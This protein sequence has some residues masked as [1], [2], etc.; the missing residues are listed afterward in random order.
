VI[1]VATRV[2]LLF[3]CFDP[4]FFCSMPFRRPTTVIADTNA[5]CQGGVDFLIR[6]LYPMARLKI[7]AIVHMEILN[8]T[9][10]YFEQRRKYQ[11]TGK[12]NKP[13][14]LY[15]HV[16]SQGGQR[17]LLR[18][19]LQTD[20]EVEHTALFPDPLKNAFSQDKSGEEEMSDLNLHAP[21]R[22]Y[23]D[24]LILETARQHRSMVTPGHPVMLMTGDEGLGRMTLAEG[25][26][27]LFFH[28]G[29]PAELYGQILCGTRFNPFDGKLFSIPLAD[30]LWELAVTF[31]NARLTSED[32]Q[33]S[34]TIQAMDRDLNWQPYHA[35]DDLLRVSWAGFSETVHRERTDGQ[36]TPVTTKKASSQAA[37]P[38][39]AKYPGKEVKEAS[40]G[41]SPDTVYKFNVN[42]MCL[43]MESL[44][45][46]DSVSVSG[47]G[48]AL[49]GMA[50]RTL[51]HYFGFLRAG[52]FVTVSGETLRTTESLR[53]LWTALKYR[54]LDSIAKAFHAVSSFKV[55]CD[56]LRKKRLT[57]MTS[58]TP[59][60]K[61]PAPTYLQLAEICG[62]ALR[63]P[64]EGVYATFVM[65]SP[66]EFVDIAIEAF[67][68]NR[69]GE[70]YLL[71]GLWL[72][73]MTREHGVHPIYARNCL[74]E[75]QAAGIIDRFTEGSTPE[76][77]FDSHTLNVL[78]VKNGGPTVRKI[79]LYHGD[80]ILPGKASVSIR[81]EKR[82]V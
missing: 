18:L 60:K 40:S 30:L 38:F 45:A 6:F 12:L 70:R 69:K 42:T 24:R 26:Q 63:I 67:E 44:V 29:K 21:I 35:K 62:L 37:R 73:A 39:T 20:T 59:K 80:F 5:I 76:T 15:H 77:R 81:L 49:E 71:T 31:G 61:R 1:D 27:P 11:R 75:A 72:E 53:S 52:H 23:C 9:Y 54:D 41:L 74:N 10:R 36:P 58:K 13:L 68:K 7:P 48:T 22:S 78:A 34:I 19:E 2:G 43:L 25:L 50:K 64:E 8:Q 46:G 32:G 14:A 82:K 16:L 57:E 65:P 17:A 28:A 3:P 4:D 56:T 47:K 55:F 33:K 66:E 79:C 51:R